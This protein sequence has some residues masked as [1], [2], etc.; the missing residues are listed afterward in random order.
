MS[1]RMISRYLKGISMSDKKTNFCINLLLYG[2]FVF[3]ILLLGL[4]LF[5]THHQTRSVNLVPFRG[6]VSY[7]SG[8]DLVSGQD[9]AAVLHAFAL[10][11]LLANL[12]IFVP[13]GVYI[14]LFRKGKGIWKNVLWVFVISMVVEIVQF[15]TK[16]GIGDIDDVILNSI[17]GLIGVLICRLLYLI[18]CDDLKVRRIIAISAPIVGVMSFVILFLA[19]R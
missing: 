15:I 6:V 13:C 19:N 11:N 5:R 7:I 18:C 10:L 12:F 2:V 16:F 4:I 1:Q 8:N 9:S 14:T 17:G 3:Y